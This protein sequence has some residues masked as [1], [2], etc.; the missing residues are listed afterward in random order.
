[1][2]VVDG[3]FANGF[4]APQITGGA[5]SPVH[6]FGGATSG[7]IELS[8]DLTVINNPNPRQ[9]FD[10]RA[11]WNLQGS[12]AT[13]V[14]EFFVLIEPSGGGAVLQAELVLTARAD[15]AVADSGAQSAQIDVSAF[16]G[17]A[18][19]LVLMWSV[20]EANTGSAFFQIDGFRMLEPDRVMADGFESRPE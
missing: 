7:N 4:F 19:R 10:Y 18:V 16:A 20:P 3:T 11:G 12:G 9:F 13:Q 17:Q 14:R 1:M 5:Y 8:Q 6:G 2:Q 15:G